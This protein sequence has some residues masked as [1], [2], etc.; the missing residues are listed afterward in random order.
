MK[1]LIKTTII[2]F[3]AYSTLGASWTEYP[4]FDQTMIDNLSKGE[5]ISFIQLLPESRTHRCE[6]IGLI[7]APID[8]VWKV[9]SDYNRY[10]E[11]M[12][13]T[14]VTFLVDPETI[15][16]FQKENISNWNQFEENLKEHRVEKHGEN[17]FYFYNRFKMPFPLKDRH[18]VL[19]VE[20]N[21]E[22]YRSKWT[23]VL[24][25]TRVYTGSWT[26]SPFEEKTGTTLVIYALDVDTGINLPAKIIQSAMKK[27]PEIIR[28]LREH[29][30]ADEITDG[31]S[32][33]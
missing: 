13:R 12:P 30:Q 15:I 2:L 23:E 9:I 20:R 14:P 6:L 32:T 22:I 10:N 16:S 11:F 17:P 1:S 29:I 3:L 8:D 7:Q 31:S 24:G 27:F 4:D 25:N 19:K 18:S 33:K 5:V 21:P 28:S 26:L